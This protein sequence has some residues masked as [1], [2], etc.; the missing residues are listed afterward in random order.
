MCKA[1]D[2][3]ASIFNSIIRVNI[4]R[5][6]EELSYQEIIEI[7]KSNG[8][9]ALRYSATATVDDRLNHLRAIGL[10]EYD[11]TTQKYRKKRKSFIKKKRGIENFS[12]LT[13]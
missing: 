13:A 7:L 6:R 1:Y 8:A 11:Y 3:T 5:K 9:Q 10:L 2:K 12:Y 4:L